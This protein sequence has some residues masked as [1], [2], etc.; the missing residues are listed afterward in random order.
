[1]RLRRAS[2]T[3]PRPALSCD[4]GHRPSP[5]G[6]ARRRGSADPDDGRAVEV[7]SVADPDRDSHPYNRGISL[8]SV[9]VADRESE[10]GPIGRASCRERVGQYVS[11]PV[12]A[13][14]LKKKKSYSPE[15]ARTTK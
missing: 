7:S 6:C 14:S 2:A 8:S 10:P 4:V 1:M 9:R 3:S 12:V 13:V 15:Q 11:I 5:L